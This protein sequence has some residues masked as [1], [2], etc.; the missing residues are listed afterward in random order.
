LI[1]KES[2]EIAA[3][4]LVS[5]VVHL[6][7]LLQ[8]QISKFG[9]SAESAR[10]SGNS[11]QLETMRFHLKELYD[12]LIAPIRSRWMGSHLVIVPHG[13]LHYV[14]FQA[15]YDGA[16]Y[17]IDEFTISYAPSAS[18][19][20][21]CQNKPPHEGRSSLVFGV[22]GENAPEILEEVQA[23]AALLPSASLFVGPEATLERL[24][25]CGPRSRFI[26]LAT[27]GEFRQDNPLFSGI[28][29][30][31]AR[32]N[33]YAGAQ[34]LLLSLWNVHD[35]SATEFMATFYRNVEAGQTKPV[36]LQQA[37]IEM[38]EKRPH[39]YYWA[40]FFLVGKVP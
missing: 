35:R 34:T 30:G 6:V 19:F 2:L 12:E 29:L 16:S 20:S 11:Q 27:Q 18:I 26:H 8:S 7:R 36:A 15:L 31:D 39:P 9:L 4:T 33:L 32:L 22:P 24:K 38:R 5:R 10:S 28:R 25:D 1:E 21:L 37:M 40:P 14:P 23:V 13:P 3:I 17:L